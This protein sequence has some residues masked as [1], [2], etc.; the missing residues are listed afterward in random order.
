M[1]TLQAP[2]NVSAAH[3]L[4]S[5][6]VYGRLLLHRSSSAF[7][8][9][10]RHSAAASRSPRPGGGRLLVDGDGGV[11]Q[12]GRCPD[13]FGERLDDPGVLEDDVEPGRGG[14]VLVRHHHRAADL[15]YPRGPDAVA[16]H[17][18]HRLGVDPGSDA[19][20][21]GL[22]GREVVHRHQ[23]IGD[24][25]H[26]RP[27]AE[28]TQVVGRPSDYLEDRSGPLEGL[29]GAGCQD[30]QRGIGGLEAGAAHR[31]VHQLDAGIGEERPGPLLRLDGERPHLDRDQTRACPLRHLLCHPVE[32]LHRW[33]REED[34]PGAGRH[35]GRR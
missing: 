16:G 35:R 31:D 6:L 13:R 2:W 34:D 25:L 19:K 23:Q 30:D 17:P 24:V 32:R 3:C 14:Q 26:H 15:E 7:C 5:L 4:A 21:M 10:N 27:V 9:R 11:E 22:G 20:G 8:S 12:R 1:M 29:G 28:L 33:Q 18:L